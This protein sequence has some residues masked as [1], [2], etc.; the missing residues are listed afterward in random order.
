MLFS[1]EVKKE[2]QIISIHPNDCLI[3]DKKKPP[4]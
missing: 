1:D 3:E 4:G 2:L